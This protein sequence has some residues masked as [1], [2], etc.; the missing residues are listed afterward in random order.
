MVRERH[1]DLRGTRRPDSDR[2]VSETVCSFEGAMMT[3]DLAE[4]DQVAPARQGAGCEPTV[5]AQAAARPRSFRRR[6][7][8]VVAH[9]PRA[10]RRCTEFQRDTPYGSHA[11]QQPACAW[12][13]GV[14]RRTLAPMARS[15]SAR[16]VKVCSG[17]RAAI[18]ADAM[19]CSYCGARQ[20]RVPIAKS[21]LIP[22]TLMVLC[23]LAA[24]AVGLAYY[25]VTT[26]GR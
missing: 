25:I 20:P 19:F 10:D 12:S 3:F 18:P 9:A 21:R 26:S 7:L 5:E 17:C 6:R 24:G 23:F 14:A 2:I 8:G 15:R 13:G 22:A 16:A 1:P 11:G 4:V